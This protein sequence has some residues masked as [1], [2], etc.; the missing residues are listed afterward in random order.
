MIPQDIPGAGTVIR[1]AYLWSHEARLGRTEGSKD[2]PVALV[3][4]KRP[5]EGQCVVVPITHREPEAPAVGIEIPPALRERLGL[6]EQRQWVVLTDVNTFHWP[7]PDLRDVPGRDPVTFVYGTLTKAFFR[8]VLA[9]MQT[10]IRARR[11]SVTGR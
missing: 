3:I 2:R 5:G 9:H 7:G 6:D 10:L 8:D 1:Y 11:S 4:A